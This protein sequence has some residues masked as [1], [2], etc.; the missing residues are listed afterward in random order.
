MPRELLANRRNCETI[1][2]DWGKRGYAISFG[3]FPDGRPAEIFIS[4]Y[5]NTTTEI[6]QVARDGAVL[7]SLALQHGCDPETIAHAITRDGGGN[8]STI[9]GAVIDS[10]VA[11]NKTVKARLELVQG[12]AVVSLVAADLSNKET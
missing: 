2:V 7:V 12:D 9:I 10:M 4:A 8:P 5:H 3:M 1:T 6:D 11:N